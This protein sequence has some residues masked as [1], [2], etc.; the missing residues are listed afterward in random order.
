MHAMESPGS[1]WTETSQI[2][3]IDLARKLEQEGAKLVIYTDI[4][5]T[6]CSWSK[7]TP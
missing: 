1:G 5:A 2:G 4:S 6:A 3:A 7:P